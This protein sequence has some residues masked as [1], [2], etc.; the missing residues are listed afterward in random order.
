MI[1]LGEWKGFRKNPCSHLVWSSL[2][3]GGSVLPN[4]RHVSQHL[5]ASSF[6][7][8]KCNGILLFFVVA[9]YDLII[10]HFKCGVK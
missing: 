5:V 10:K 3:E 1:G 7:D 2:Q 6:T 4:G 8:K 9:I